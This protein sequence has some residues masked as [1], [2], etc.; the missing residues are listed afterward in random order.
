MPTRIYALAKELKID[1]KELVDVCAKAGIT[2]KG[3]ALASLEDEE[4]AKIKEYLK[5]P[6]PQ[7]TREPTKSAPAEQVAQEAGESTDATPYSR[8]DYIATAGSS[9]I[10]VLDGKDNA[11]AESKAKSTDNDSPRPAKKRAPII[12]VAPMPVA[13]QPVAPAPEEVK[14]Q[15]PEIRLP[16]DAIQG[17]KKGARA[18][19]EQLKKSDAKPAK[20]SRGPTNP[21]QNAEA[22]GAGD[23]GAKT[24]L[25]KAAR[26]RKDKDGKTSD[27]EK[28]AGMASTRVDRQK[29]RRTKARGRVDRMGREDD[30]SPRRRPRTLTRRGNSNTAA[31]R[32]DAI[33]LELPC[34]VRT[35]SEA[36]GVPATKVIMTLMGLG[37]Q[38]T[39]NQQIDDELVELLVGELGVEIE[40]KQAETLEDSLI[41]K[42]M[43]QEEDA[44]NLQTRAPVVTFLGHVDHGKTSLLD[45][46]IGTNVVDGEAGGIT[47]HIRAFEIKKDDRKIAYVDTPGHAAFTEMRARGANVTDIAVLVIAADDGIMPQTVEAISHA[48][49]A[50]VPIVVAL[51]KMDLPGADPNRCMTQMPEY[52]LT[53]SEWGGDIEVVQTSATTGDG[54]DDLLETLLTVAE[55]H[56]YKAN[57]NRQAFGT[58]LEAHQEQGRGVVAKLIVQNGTLK[59]G[60]IIVCGSAQGRVK[61]MYDTLKPNMRLESAEPSTPV[62]ITGFDIA[63]EA[64]EAFYVLDDIAKAR[65]IAESRNFR[66]REA[67]LSGSTT[68]ISF[69]DFQRRLEE[70]R[71]GEAIETATL[72]LIVRADVRGSIEAI[73]KELAKLD[74]PEVQVKILQKSVGG[75]TVADV[76]LAHASQAIIVGFNVIPDEAARGLANDRDVEI[77]RYDIIY[78]LTEDIK[79]MVEGKLKPEEK[80]VELGRA[81]VKQ[82]FSISRVGAVAGSYV[83]NGTITRGCRIRVNRDGRTIGDYPLDTLRHIKDDVKEV[84]RGME[85]GIKLAGFNDIKK[86]DI[87][88]GYRIEEVARTLD[89]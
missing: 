64:G 80:I 6:A 13:S 85:C 74:H 83:T 51:N 56:E 11:T 44:A 60:D 39:I 30:T 86:D 42:I 22:A 29:A 88:E 66:S 21:A 48:K 69:E 10:K 28:M 55:L 73:E 37:T 34:T 70:G 47:Q 18:P 5:G 16:K 82:V 45:Y 27:K 2:G 46:L 53:P 79:M 41:S 23:I 4:V 62:N 52:E 8:D 38:I 35:F 76:T 67:S 75:I 49:A 26:G 50:E 24:P 58:C 61:A 68:K 84:P 9:K 59:K 15:K 14:A 78:K 31:P 43:N 1:S 87:L 19:L 12:N 25:G 7:E 63:P 77:R 72:N 17:H 33:A 32:K 40:F 89:S 54:M 57:P 81:I 20:S 3:S 71:L 36:A 65:E